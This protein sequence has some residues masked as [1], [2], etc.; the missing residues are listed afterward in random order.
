MPHRLDT[1]QLDWDPRSETV[2]VDQI[3]AYDAMRHRCPVAYSDYLGWSLFRHAD[4]VRV[5]D[6]HTTRQRSA[7]RLQTDKQARAPGVTLT[8]NQPSHGRWSARPAI[9]ITI[10]SSSLG[11]LSRFH[12]QTVASTH[13][14]GGTEQAAEVAHVV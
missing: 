2:L 6:D 14:K 13:A 4:V 7:E 11:R 10:F 9:E 5:L 3:A 8:D 1:P 12:L